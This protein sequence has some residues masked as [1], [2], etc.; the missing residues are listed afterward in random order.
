[1][2]YIKDYLKFIHN[3]KVGRGGKTEVSVI[4]EQQQSDLKPP[5]P[6]Q[7]KIITKL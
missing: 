7:H 6:N 3:Y 4:I 1:M 2:P 5:L